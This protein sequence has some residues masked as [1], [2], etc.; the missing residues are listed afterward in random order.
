MTED[1]Y[2]S[3]VDGA[4]A[5]LH[6]ADPVIHGGGPVACEVLTPKALQN[7]EQRG[8]LFL[9]SFYRSDEVEVMQEELTRLRNAESVR[10]S[11]LAVTEPASGEVRSIFATHTVSDVFAALSRDE[12][13]LGIVRHLLGGDVY[14]HQ[15]RLNLKP[16]FRGKEFYWHSDFETWHTEDGMPAMRAVS[17]SIALKDN[18]EYNGP[19]MVIPGSHKYYCQCT[20]RTPEYHYQQSLKKQDFGV[21]SDEQ[22]QWLV[23]QS[24]IV[25]PKGPAGSVLLFECNLMHGSNSNITPSARSNAFFVFNSTENTLR[26]PFASEH[27]RP[28][29]LANREPEPLA[30][31]DFRGTMAA[32]VAQS[33]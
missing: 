2:P 28:W 23:D 27:E 16:G 11:E 21:P 8:Y 32:T 19:L 12:R 1:K 31:M 24:E 20:G 18:L 26:K 13:L 7:Y 10:Q 4:A 22:L 9:E 14:L 5:I 33:A 30:A 25:V 15:S 17:C 6:R 29:Y 3:R